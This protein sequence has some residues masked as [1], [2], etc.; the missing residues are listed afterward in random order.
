MIG[1]CTC[2]QTPV[3]LTASVIN[4]TVFPANR[5]YHS[6]TMESYETQ[7]SP[8]EPPRGSWLLAAP[9]VLALVVVAVATTRQ[10]PPDVV[11][12]IN[13]EHISRAQFEAEVRM[14]DV[15]YAVS[16]RDQTTNRAAVLNRLIGDTL[17]LQAARDADIVADP[18]AVQAEL[19]RVLSRLGMSK[20]EMA[21]L[22]EEHRLTW[23]DFKQSLRDYL[24]IRNFTD[25]TLLNE[26]AAIDRQRTLEQWMAEQ[27]RASEMDFDPDFLAE[28]NPDGADPLAIDG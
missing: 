19:E 24:T 18:D 13:G 20:E 28:I 6:K 3:Y 22:L 4:D 12:T 5:A 1:V 15:R 14:Q 2:R 7:W 25:K 9:L 21:R 8:G 16:H 10:R 26:V 23:S 17:T 11:A 27:Y